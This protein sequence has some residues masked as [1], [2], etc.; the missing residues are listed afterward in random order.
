MLHKSLLALAP[1]WG[2]TCALAQTSPPQAAPAA[3]ATAG[4][5]N[6]STARNQVEAVICATPGFAKVDSNLWVVYKT[7][8]GTL[9][10][11][12]QADFKNQQRD[13]VLGRNRCQDAACLRPLYSARLQTL[14]QSPAVAASARCTSAPALGAAG[15]A[16][17]PAGVPAGVATPRKPPAAN[18]AVPATALAPALPPGSRPVP[19]QQVASLQEEVDETEATLFGQTEFEVF[20]DRKAPALAGV[21]SYP[22]VLNF[23]RPLAYDA[24][25]APPE[26]PPTREDWLLNPGQSYAAPPSVADHEVQNVV[27]SLYKL[28][29]DELNSPRLRAAYNQCKRHN[30]TAYEARDRSQPGGPSSGAMAPY[31]TRANCGLRVVRRVLTVLGVPPP[32]L[33]LQRGMGLAFQTE[34]LSPGQLFRALHALQSNELAS[35]FFAQMSRELALTDAQW[36]AAEAA[37]LQAYANGAPATL[38]D[39]RQMAGFTLV[40]G[41]ERMGGWMARYGRVR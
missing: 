22:V 38:L 15:A 10:P 3:P 17:V 23:G 18:A 19:I 12:A 32:P 27:T 9:P 31:W 28:L 30:A 39:A 33:A 11:E 40:Q 34:Y 5:Q 14:C 1:V 21:G 8:L 26:Q 37:A 29:F 36:V 2:L 20:F 4:A 35:D 7:V 16:A 13:W 41:T 25:F 24:P 6:C